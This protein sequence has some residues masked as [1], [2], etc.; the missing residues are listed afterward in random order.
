MTKNTIASIIIVWAVLG[1]GG[2]L[3]WVDILTQP[4]GELS[5][6]K[7]YAKDQSRLHP[8]TIRIKTTPKDPS[9]LPAVTSKNKPKG[10]IPPDF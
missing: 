10:L 8:T 7:Y 1:G 9:R 5:V 4:K 3:A 6:I 2:A